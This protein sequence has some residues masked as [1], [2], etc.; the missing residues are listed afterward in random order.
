VYPAIAVLQALSEHKPSWKDDGEILWIG[1]EDGMEGEILSRQDIEYETIPAAGLHGVGIGNL[2]GNLIQLIRGYL[3]AGRILRNYRPDA[4]FFTGGYLAVPVAYAGRSVPSLVFIPDIEPGLAIRTIANLSSR[5]AV[6]VSQTQDHIPAGKQVI[7]TGY[8]VRADLLKWTRNQALEILNL[9]PGLPTLL[10]FG[11][12][13]GAR[14]INRALGL[15]LPILLREMQIV[16]ISGKLDW[17]EMAAIQGRLPQKEQ[18][19]YRLYPFLHEEMG[20]ALRIADLVVSRS[21]ASILGEYPAFGLPA[22]LV[23]YPHAWQYQKTNAKYLADRGAAVIIQDEA[24]DDE[25]VKNI[26]SLMRDQEALLMMGSAMKRIAKPN[27]A[28]AIAELL[29]TLAGNAE[30]GSIQ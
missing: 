2:P 5:I 14:S 13:S 15:I 27:A 17:E 8:P 20:A 21:G 30:G 7:E 12:S 10:V 26:Q 11:G 19:N 18:D 29:L 25:L 4:M 6:S 28:V 3:K 16:H 1:G 24:L 9:D 22:I 23:P